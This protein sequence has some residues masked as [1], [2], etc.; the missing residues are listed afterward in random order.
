MA[1]YPR[2]SYD[3]TA[4]LVYFA[5]MLDKLRLH[6]AKQL[7][8]DYHEN[9]G[10]GFDGRMCRFLNVNYER[11]CHYALSNPDAS[12]E[13]VLEW[14]A[15]QG[16]RLNEVD[17]L[18]W[19]GF[20]TKRGWRDEDGAS[21]YLAKAKADAGLAEREDIQTMFEFFEVDEKRRD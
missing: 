10:K 5:R 20:A 17:V 4:G 13:T 16:R 6:A 18:V 8:A 11:L 2:S 19:N 3:L 1:Q 9:L 15:E 12:D 7:P 21:E 14:C